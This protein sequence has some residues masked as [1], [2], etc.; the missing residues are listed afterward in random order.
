MPFCGITVLYRNQLVD[1]FHSIDQCVSVNVHGP[2]SSGK[3][4]FVY[5]KHIESFCQIGVMLLVIMQQLQ[6]CRMAECLNRLFLRKD[7]GYVVQVI[8]AVN[9]QLR[10][11]VKG[12]SEFN[13]AQRLFIVFSELRNILKSIAESR[14]KTMF[15]TDLL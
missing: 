3:I 6:Q 8:R 12:N 13:G 1:F 9:K 10:R 14:E 15:I 11:V 2:G 5:Q 7:V 4:A